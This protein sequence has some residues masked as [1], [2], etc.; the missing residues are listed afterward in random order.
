MKTINEIRKSINEERARSAWDKGVKVYAI[1][2]LNDL[3]E[4]R[5]YNNA[6]YYI[7]PLEVE[8]E[9]LNGA[10][11]WKYFSYGA[12]SLIYDCDIAKRLCNPTELKKTRNGEK[13][14]EQL[15]KLVRCS[16]SCT[17]SSL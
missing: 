14:S 15:R 10:S 9:L 17:V 2:L 11:D 13:K 16:S 12:S 1:E 5:D 4:Y 6:D 3:E 8:T 7:H